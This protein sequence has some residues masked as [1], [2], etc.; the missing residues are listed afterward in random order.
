MWYSAKYLFTSAIIVGSEKMTKY[1][2]AI[3][4]AE[5]H[6]GGVNTDTG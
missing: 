6:A 2:H 3:Y 4:K 1:A 5:H